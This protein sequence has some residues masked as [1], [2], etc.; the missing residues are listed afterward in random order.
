MWKWLS[1]LIERHIVS[2]VPA[3]LAY[4]E[5]DCRKTSCSAEQFAL[6]TDRLRSFTP[7]AGSPVAAMAPPAHRSPLSLPGT[8]RTPLAGPARG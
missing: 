1:A 6:C 3:E 2:D 7:A 4:C 5:Y 8:A